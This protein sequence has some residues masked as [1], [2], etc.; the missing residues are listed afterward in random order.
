MKYRIALVAFALASA[1]A[2]AAEAAPPYSNIN[3]RQYD[4]Q[5]RIEQGVR[6]GELT[7]RE[8]A[9]LQRREAEVRRYERFARADGYLSPYERAQLN[10][11][12]DANSREIARQKRDGQFR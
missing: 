7:H 4:Q 3:A 8:A 10:R 2:T 9:Y 6:S 11:M 12:L 1:F 5:R